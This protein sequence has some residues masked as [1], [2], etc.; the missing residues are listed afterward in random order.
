M[1]LLHVRWCDLIDLLLTLAARCFVLGCVR[2]CVIVCWWCVVVFVVVCVCLVR[3]VG[4]LLLLMLCLVCVGMW[5]APLLLVR[6]CVGVV[7]VCVVLCWRA[8]GVVRRV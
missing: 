6:F 4:L 5:S 1:L 7:G 8:V 3:C 2:L